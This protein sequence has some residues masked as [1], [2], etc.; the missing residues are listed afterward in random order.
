MILVTG[1]SGTVGAAVARRLAAAGFPLRLVARDPRRIAVRGF[2]IESTGADFSDPDT[3]ATAFR[4]AERAFIATNDPLRPQQDENLL[5]A[6]AQAGVK[7]V[8]RI[9]ALMVTDLGADDLITRWHRECE[10]RLQASGLAW[11]V[12][13]PRAF[14]SNTLGWARSLADG[15]VRA[16]Y[17]S[18]R[19]ACVDPR[20]VA[21]V[22]VR[23]L[24]EPGHEGQAYPVTGPAAISSAEQVQQLAET[25]GR[26]IRFEEISVDEAHRALMERYPRPV[27]D[28]LAQHLHRRGAHAKC[29]VE[30]TVER[31]TG[32]PAACFRMWARDHAEA[33]RLAAP[34]Q[35]AAIADH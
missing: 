31:V 33:F 12:V 29:Q 20:D 6:A 10:Q 13:R 34:S 22:A 35:I 28:A 3:L 21:E 4:G 14:M 5:A 16:P 23:A 11:T 32:R 1:A 17:G 9:S 8:V 25:L 19:V 30:Q 2:G 27:A 24:T 18:A 15:V 26:P 7:Q